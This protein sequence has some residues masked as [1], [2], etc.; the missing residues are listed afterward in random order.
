MEAL[1]LTDEKFGDLYFISFLGCVLSRQ[2]YLNDDEF[3]T[4]YSIIMGQVIPI[5][6]LE[7]INN[8][9]SID[10]ESLLDDQRLFGLTGQAD[11]VFRNY[12]YQYK[13]KNYI[14]FVRLRIP[15]N[16]NIINGE[17][18]GRV[19]YILQPITTEP[20]QI[21]YISIAWSNYG[22]IYVVA[23]RRIPNII[24]LLFRGTYSA[25]T[26][27]LYSKPTSAF[28][29]TICNDSR[30]N[31]EQFL[32][33]IFKTSVELIHTIIESITYLATNFLHAQQEN[34]VK[35]FTAGHSLGGAMCSNFSYLWM[36]IKKTTPYNAA[37]YNILADNIIC[38]SVGTPRC[39]SESVA[40]KFCNFVA[41]KKILFLRITTRLDPVPGLPP[42]KFGY[43]HPCSHNER[44]RRNI[45][46][47]CDAPLRPLLFNT[48]YDGNLNCKNIKLYKKYLFTTRDRAFVTFMLYHT[49]YMYIS[50][51][52]G[53]NFLNSFMGIFTP[54]EISRN[55][56]G[57]TICRLIMCTNEDK[58][59]VFFNVNEARNISNRQDNID[60]QNLIDNDK[61]Q[62]LTS[63]YM[64][65][66]KSII[67]SLTKPIPAE[68]VRMTNRAFN[69][70]IEQ[71]TT[72][73]D[74][75]LESEI[76]LWKRPAQNIFNEET[77]PLLGCTTAALRLA[78]LPK[79]E[80]ERALSGI[81]QDLRQDQGQ[82]QGIGQGQVP[83]Q[84]QDPGQGIGQDPGQGQDPGIGQGQGQVP[85][86]GIRQ[87]HDI[88]GRK[89]RN[90]NKT[91]KSK[92]SKKSKK[93]FK[94]KKSKTRRH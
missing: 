25:K 90:K 1:E 16:I 50:F 59:V 38:V 55:S 28:P 83:G 29:I 22:E 23:D 30:G 35:I 7:N 13:G 58:R 60:E 73:R 19:Q 71:M 32:Y 2:A 56:N 10:L 8:V 17:Q 6:L 77:V 94:L 34:S 37:P 62:S 92:R 44:E 27:A 51:L 31:P 4:N 70:L 78:A 18:S 26:A 41:Q 93:R 57:D 49:S 76:H 80:D 14:D 67:K 33:G 65:I 48:N 15:E 68:D 66:P 24:F 43:Q 75:I 42:K 54:M 85:G 5:R 53:F 64:S 46:Q 81:L 3:L 72:L 40:Q 9:S 63:S 86:Q 39:M 45:S 74:D 21:K 88:G 47:E 61:P 11:D 91:K 20:N 36:G 87:W 69:L 89:M 79:D 12:E 52:K 82:G 84:G